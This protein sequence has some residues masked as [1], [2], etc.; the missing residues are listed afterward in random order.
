M[1]LGDFVFIGERVGYG[2][3]GILGRGRDLD[4]TRCSRHIKKANKRRENG[5]RFF[6]QRVGNKCGGNQQW[7]PPQQWRLYFPMLI[8][9]I[10]V[11]EQRMNFNRNL[12]LIPCEQS[13]NCISWNDGRIYNDYKSIWYRVNNKGK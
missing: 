6:Q 8:M 3:I 9:T 1:A 11:E 5:S 2:L 7:R 13:W 4:I 12:A 10:K